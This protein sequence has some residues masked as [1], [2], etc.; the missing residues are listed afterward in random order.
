[1]IAAAT[2]AARKS[3]ETLCP[4]VSRRQPLDGGSIALGGSEFISE[5][6]GEKKTFR[7][8]SD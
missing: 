2:M 3:G 5:L 1:M 8:V 7:E 4:A 6:S